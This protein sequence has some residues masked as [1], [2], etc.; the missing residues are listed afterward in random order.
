VTP[1]LV[2]DEH[3]RPR[4][5]CPCHRCGTPVP[6]GYSFQL[7]HLRMIGWQLFAEAETVQRCSHAQN[8]LVVPQADGVRAALMPI[9]GEAARPLLPR[10]DRRAVDR[11][12]DATVR[13]PDATSVRATV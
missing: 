8:V 12:D 2:I 3:G 11:L 13:N 4:A 10:G 6:V 1:A 9:Y 7:A 5:T